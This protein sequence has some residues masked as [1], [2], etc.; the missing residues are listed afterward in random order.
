MNLKKKITFTTNSLAYNNKILINPTEMVEDFNNYYVSIATSLD[1]SI[2][3][4]NTNPVSFLKGDF[5]S[6][7]TVPPV[8]SQ[9]LSDIIGSLKNKSSHL[10]DILVSLI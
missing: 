8:L 4:S 10:Q 3:P 2:P 6:S 7:M 1:G 9:D 5:P